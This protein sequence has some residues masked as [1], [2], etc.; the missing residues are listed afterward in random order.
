MREDMYKVIVERPR[1]GK[2]GD[3]AA[4]RLRQDFD[5]PTRLGMRAGYGYRNL[6]ENLAPLRRYLRAQLGRPWNKVFSE[7][8]AGIDRRN[9]VQQHIHQHIRDFIAIDVEVH[10]GRLVDLGDRWR[11]FRGDFGVSQEL[12]VD[13]RSGLIR[14]NKHYR[15]WRRDAAANRKREAA[16]TA[17]RRRMI[18]ES[19]LL[20]LLEGIWY[21]VKVGELPTERVI[22]SVIDG[23]THRRVLVEPRYDVVLRRPISRAV[24]AN[25]RQCKE[26]YGSAD[27]YAVSKRQI[28][29]R[30]IKAHGLRHVTV[31]V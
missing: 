14:L 13:P 7:I 1:R 24:Q 3:A 16:Q 15:D 19:T 8:C 26:L 10:E 9:T 2:K 5:G 31:G 6:N 11:F 17:A 29:T 30:E 4:A 23:K 18:D 27:F 28:S 22:E 20:L 21:R 25:L 12:Y